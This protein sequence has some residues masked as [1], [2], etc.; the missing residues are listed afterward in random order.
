VIVVTD[1]SVVLNLCFLKQE[2]LL[3][4]LFGNVLAPPEV[5]TE[6][7]RLVAEDERFFG[8]DFP[9]YVRVVSPSGA[10]ASL[11]GTNR[12]QSGEIAAISL[13]LEQEADAVLM[14]E[15]AGRKAATALGLHAIFEIRCCGWPGNLLESA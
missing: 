10:V 6:F 13:A 4:V 11:Q 7:R 14:D 8:L 1:T 9:R 5:E 15:Q 3:P 12:L 2:A